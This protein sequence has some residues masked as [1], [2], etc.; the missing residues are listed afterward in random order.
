MT[1]RI[2][3]TTSPSILA[4]LR[5]AT[6]R[7]T[8]ES[9]HRGVS[10][11]VDAGS[12]SA[13]LVSGRGD[14]MDAPTLRTFQTKNYDAQVKEMPAVPVTVRE[15]LNQGVRNVGVTA[16][17]SGFDAEAG[18]AT[19]Q[20]DE[21]LLDERGVDGGYRVLSAYA[22][23][24][25]TVRVGAR[26]SLQGDL[27]AGLVAAQGTVQ[28]RRRMGSAELSGQ[29]QGTVGATLRANGDLTVDFSRR[30][31]VRLQ[32]GGDVFAGARVGI[33]G[34]VANDY[35]GVTGR[36]EA[37]AG[38]GAKARVDA[39]IENGRIRARV[40]IGA[41]LGIG[42]SVSLG[43]DVNYQAIGNRAREL[44]GQAVSGLSNLARRGFSAVFGG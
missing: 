28:G 38:I 19:R 27:E 9:G 23:G 14:S 2:P 12:G 13:S 43:V 7:N 30:P 31:T 11:E 40:E 16:G 35:A 39:G 15:R 25:G 29:V 34:R 42:G 10:R 1:T 22:Q 4:R 5:E 33:E 17:E 18:V 21:K 3:G 26:T 8:E 44:G 37:M 20:I 32:A 36:A 6:R 24:S 41:C